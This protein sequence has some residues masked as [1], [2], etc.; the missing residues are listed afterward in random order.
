[1]KWFTSI[2]REFR[3]WSSDRFSMSGAGLFV[4]LFVS[5]L[6]YHET[7]QFKIW[8][9][10]INLQQNWRRPKQIILPTRPP[11]FNN[12][13]SLLW[14]SET[15]HSFRTQVSKP[16]CYITRNGMLPKPSVWWTSAD[17]S[18]VFCWLQIHHRNEEP[19]LLTVPWLCLQVLRVSKKWIWLDHSF[20]FN[21]E[22]IFGILWRISRMFTQWFAAVF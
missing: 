6:G 14:V 12:S 4:C 22:E 11:L 7:I 1:M 17:E 3:R 19:A 18:I 15:K 9:I 13:Q 20:H 10:C 8:K 2:L 16:N 21:G 5:S